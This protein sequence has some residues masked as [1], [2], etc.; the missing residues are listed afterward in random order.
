[1]GSFWSG[2]K[3]LVTG[4]TGFKGSWLCLWLDHLGAEVAGLALPPSTDPSLFELASIGRRIQSHIGDIRDLSTV[5]GIF[6]SFHPDVVF[7]LAAQSLV[8]RSYADPVGTYATNVM[9]TIHVLEA[10]RH[11]PSVRSLVVV[12][13][14]KCYEGRTGVWGYREDEPMGGHDP[15]SSSKGAAELV[16]SGFRRSFLAG[17]SPVGVATAR[18][19]NAIGGGDWSEDRLIPDCMR[20]L[21]AGMPIAIRNPASVRPWQHVVEPLAGYLK[22]AERLYRRPERFSRGWNF[23]P[24]A[25]HA[26]PVAW[27]AERL[28]KLW[29]PGSAW[30]RLEAADARHEAAHLTLDSTLARAMLGWDC[31]LSLEQALDWVVEWYRGHACGDAADRLTLAQIELYDKLAGGV[32]DDD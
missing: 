1:M 23:G 12:T 6:D 30:Q 19:G 26:R 31:K 15:Y 21:L 32:G 14:D 25:E 4:H 5:R 16:T 7:H 28:V 3:V 17:T 10:V 11:T 8:R 20:S 13:S 29:G 2:Q 27:I 18:A 9:G 22:L 24:Q